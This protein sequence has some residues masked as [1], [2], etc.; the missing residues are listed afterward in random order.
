[1]KQKLGAILAAIFGLAILGLLAFQHSNLQDCRWHLEMAFRD[2][3]PLRLNQLTPLE[4]KAV[5]EWAT[6]NN[7]SFNAAMAGNRDIRTLEMGNQTCIVL[8]LERGA[9]GG[10]PVYCFDKNARLI[11]RFD[12]VE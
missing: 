7:I 8:L 1:M 11:N 4:R 5:A 3:A 6:L 12:N 2:K 9:I 10:S